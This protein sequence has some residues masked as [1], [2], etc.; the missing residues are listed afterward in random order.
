M[1]WIPNRPS[2]TR[3]AACPDRK[4]GVRFAVP[5]RIGAMGEGGG[6]SFAAYG[7]RCAVPGRVRAMGEGGGGS[8][9]AYGRDAG[10]K[11]GAP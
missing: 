5:G 9:A 3:F 6:G 7:V 1:D 2:G 8:F 10:L 11:T 4:R